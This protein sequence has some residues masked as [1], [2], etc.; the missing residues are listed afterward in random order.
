MKKFVTILILLYHSAIGFSQEGTMWR[1]F[2]GDLW[3][4]FFDRAIAYNEQNEYASAE[5]Q[6]RRAQQLLLTEYGLNEETRPT[7]CHILYRRAH[8]LFMIDGMQDSSYTYF[9][10]LYDLSKTLNDTS[11]INTFR[12]E[13]TLM[14]SMMDLE[15]GRIRDCCILLENEKQLFDRLKEGSHLFYK[16]HYYKNLSQTYNHILVS[17]LSSKGRDFSFLESPYTIVR[18]N[19]FYTDYISTYKELVNLSSLL[20]KDNPKKLTEDLILLAEHCRV[21]DDEYLAE[22]TYE[23][24]FYIWRNNDNHNNNT[25]I[26]L[27]SSYL[28]FCNRTTAFNHSL[29]QKV[30]E[31]FDSIILN[32][33]S[34]NLID[35]M[36]YYSVRLQDKSIGNPQKEVYV[37]KICN[38]LAEKD[39]YLILYFICGYSPTDKTIA[40]INNINILIKYLALSSVYYYELEDVPMADLLLNKAKFFSILLPVGDRLFIEELNN[41]IAKSAETIGDVESHYKYKALNITGNTARGITPTLND[42]LSVA[43]YGDANSRIAQITE[44]INLFGNST[45]DKKLLPFYINLS[46]A[47]LDNNNYSFAD[48]NNAIADSITKLMIRDGDIISNSTISELSLCKARSAYLKGDL[49]N[50]RVFA[51]ESNDK[52]ENINAVDLL[53]ELYADEEKMLDSIVFNQFCRTAAFINN[54]YPFLTEKERISFSQNTE[55]LWFSRIPKYADR[56]ANDT[57][58]LSIA[59]NTTLISKGT[60][61]SVSTAVIKAARESN[62]NATKEALHSFLQHKTESVNDTSERVRGNRSFYLEVLEK[63]MQRSSGAIVHA[64]EYI[65]SDWREIA[66][67]LSKDEMAIEFV[68]YTPLGALDNEDYLGALFITQDKYPQIVRLCKVSEVDTLKMHFTRTGLIRIYD[69]LWRPILSGNQNITKLWF[70]PSKHLFQINIEAALPDSIVAYRVSSTRNV[71]RNNDAPDFSEI[72]LFGGLNYDSKDTISGDGIFNH[73]ALSIIRSIDIDEERIG[74]SYLKGSMNEVIS[75]NEILSHTDTDIQLYVDKDGTEERFKNLS[76]IGISLLHVATHGFYIKNS[77][78]VSNIGNR[79]MRKSGLF[80]SGAKTIWKG[81]KEDYYGDDGILLSEEIEV[82]DFNKLNLVIL[83][84]CGTGLGNPTNDGVYG[85]Q[86]AFKKAGAQTIIMSLWN[87]DDNA[88]ALMMETFYNELVKTK[89]KRKAF[90]KAQSTVRE[91]YEDPYYWA[92]FIM[93]D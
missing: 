68:E 35:A 41:A 92:A 16:Y 23:Q 88:T 69:I 76:G 45:Y 34:I 5:K 74:L 8:N 48:V 36:D 61:I 12:I 66:F 59:Y 71:L 57:L 10:E 86:R 63:E 81:E 83:S 15:K 50:A 26:N 19:D 78:N 13:S 65:F 31:E 90:Q 73:T 91:K 28:S 75:A 87:V 25:Y 58:L 20:N 4:L 21:P 37:K 32:N 33:T 67:R 42:W 43:N 85:L 46:N 53:S 1:R 17:F 89:S 72:A 14:L 30:S 60:N 22:K 54:N 79:V 40:S 38:Y 70:S 2:E 62:E 18:Y 77:D 9:K 49:H 44:G 64:N 82:L 55:F 7:Y 24:A 29:K 56:Y 47:Y 52:D 27:C 11:T 39:N 6:F 93:L 80:M 51:K 84:A 3:R